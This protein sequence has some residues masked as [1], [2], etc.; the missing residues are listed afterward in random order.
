M[1]APKP[2]VFSQ[3][4]KNDSYLNDRNLINKHK[5]TE[6]IFITRYIEISWKLFSNKNFLSVLKI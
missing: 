5:I 1:L 6:D 3:K 2:L 4:I